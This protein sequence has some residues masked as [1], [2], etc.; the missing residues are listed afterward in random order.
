[1]SVSAALSKSI[2]FNSVELGLSKNKEKMGQLL[3]MD[4]HAYLGQYALKNVPYSLKDSN[5]PEQKKSV[6]MQ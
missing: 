2:D 3:L 5:W 1:M 4:V 6:C